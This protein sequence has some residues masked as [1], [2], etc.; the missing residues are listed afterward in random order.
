MPIYTKTGDTGTTAVFGGKRVSKSDLQIEA[1]GAIDELTSFIGWTLEQVSN[2]DELELLPKIQQSLYQIM[3]FLAGAQTD[4]ASLSVE[5]KGFEKLIDKIAVDL[6]PLN[7]F[8]L[9]QGGELSSRYHIVR[10]LC[11]R[12]ERTVIKYLSTQTMNHNS[13]F[14]IQYLNRLS[15]LFFMLARRNTKGEE[16]VT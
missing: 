14:I 12:S 15:D 2:K 6:P 1:S 3:G 11:R 13:E 16:S 4:V 9:P 8:I 7:R 10:V 5:V